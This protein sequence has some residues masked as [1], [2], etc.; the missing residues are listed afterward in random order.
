[1]WEFGKSAA[2]EKKTPAHCGAR[3]GRIRCDEKSSCDPLL[4]VLHL[5]EHLL[6]HRVVP[7][8]TYAVIS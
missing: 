6:V 8:N 4:E 7:T 5:I 2:P 3:M 1:M